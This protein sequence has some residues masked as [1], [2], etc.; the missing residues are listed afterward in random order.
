MDTIIDKF[1]TYAPNL[2]D[3]LKSL[4]GATPTEPNDMQLQEVRVATSL[5]VLLKSRSVKV[6]GVQL[7]IT[8]MLLARATR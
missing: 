6:L 5:S 4:G 2:Y 3:L 1:V 8:L 7:L